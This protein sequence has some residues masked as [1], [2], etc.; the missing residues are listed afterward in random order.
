MDQ[1]SALLVGVIDKL[2]KGCAS[3]VVSTDSMPDFSGFHD[4]PSSDGEDGNL[5]A[6]TTDPLDELDKLSRA[7]EKDNFDFFRALEDLSGHFHGEEEKG[8]L[9]SE[10]LASILASSLQCRPSADSV[11]QTCNRIKLPSNVPNLAMPVTNSAI[12]KAMSVGGKLIDTRLSHTTV[13]S[14]RL[15]CYYNIITHC[16]YVCKL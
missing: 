10:C 15:W 6:R 13:W 1:L 12:T 9:L 14:A 3:D 7:P 8:E 11:E 5:P 4:L 2:D 16:R